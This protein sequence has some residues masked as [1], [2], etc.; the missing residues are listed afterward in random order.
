MPDGRTHDLIT[1]VTGAAGAPAVLNTNLPDMGPPNAMV[2]LGAY[3]VSGLLFSPDLDLHS[4]PYRRWR[5]LRWIWLPYQ[6][7][8]PHRSWISHSLIIGPI[9]RVVYLAAMLCLLSFVALGLLNLI[10][11][12]DPTG[13]V[14]E[15]TNTIAA[16]I[17]A[18]PA[19][20]GY[21]VAGF[22]LGAAVHSL[23]D[24]VV[25]AVKRRL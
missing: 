3:L 10:V 24:T 8:V 25:T 23:T 6:R 20:I 12:V 7:L 4:G 9:L 15:I 16:W 5:K 18:H 2:L 22:F 14:R 13:K 19:T 21:A 17:A 11:P 1:L